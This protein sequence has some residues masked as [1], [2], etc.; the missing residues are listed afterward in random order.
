MFYAAEFLKGEH[1]YINFRKTGSSV[2]TSIR[3]VTKIE[4][5]F[6]ENNFLKLH[7]SGNGFLYNM[8]R[9]L[10]GTI[11]EYAN[12]RIKTNRLHQVFEKAD[13]NLAG[14]TAP[15]HGLFLNKVIYE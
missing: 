9:I 3:N 14:I 1:D 5:V 15:A 8:V 10:T 11:L 6:L 12:N 7:Y 13:R 4:P 2:K